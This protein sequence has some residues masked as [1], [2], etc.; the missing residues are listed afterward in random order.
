M[1]SS[2][3]PAKKSVTHSNMDNAD[4]M[5]LEPQNNSPGT[6]FSILLQGVYIAF[7]SAP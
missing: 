1:G 5:T 2:F 3:R 7:Q 6:N 4:D